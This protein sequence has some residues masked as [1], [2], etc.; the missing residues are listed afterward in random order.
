M[1]DNTHY[2]LHPVDAS[3]ILEIACPLRDK[4]CRYLEIKRKAEEILHLGREDGQGDTA[5]ESHYD[6]IRDEL[7]YDTHLADSHYNEEY[8][9]HD[10]CND[11]ALHAILA[12]NTCYDY[13]E[14]TGRTSDKEVRTS[15]E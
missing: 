15:E 5:C 4:A 10:G 2:E 3:Y 12:D 1:L 11:E 6:R 7:E 14:C 9:R 13:D 8:S